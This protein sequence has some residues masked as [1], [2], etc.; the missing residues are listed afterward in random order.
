MIKTNWVT[1]LKGENERQIIYQISLSI[2]FLLSFGVIMQATAGTYNDAFQHAFFGMIG[3]SIMLSAQHINYRHLLKFK[4]VYYTAAIMLFL[5]LRTPLSVSING[6]TRWIK[7]AGISIQIIEP[8][9]LLLIIFISVVLYKNCYLQLRRRSIILLLEIW[10]L[11]GLQAV[12]ALVISS[13]LSSAIIVLGICFFL[14]LLFTDRTILHI[15][16]LT[17]GL[18]GIKIFMKWFSN[19]LP[20][21]EELSSYPYQL[22]RIAAHLDP[23]KYNTGSG[24]QIILSMQAVFSGGLTG[25]GLG[26]GIIKKLLPEAN[27]DLV[28]A[29]LTEEL[30]ILGDIMVI[31]LYAFLIISVVRIALSCQ[32][33]FG[34]ILVS[35]VGI[36]IAIQVILN[37][38]VA[39][40]F[41]PNT[42]VS[43]P[44]ISNGGTS[45][46][47][48][49]SEIAIV[50]SVYRY[51]VLGKQQNK[52]EIKNSIMRQA[53]T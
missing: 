46:V 30:G 21:P 48:L 41:I 43:L 25:R 38:A 45:V 19:H 8:I 13:N 20:Q 50:L 1:Y 22:S 9:K 53:E 26:N 35:G 14:T 44:W 40:N 47:L 18:A 42:G 6:A 37:I 31:L 32:D 17:G 33:M 5:L 11:I 10:A 34:M 49:C 4:W 2:I 15:S 3:V 12:L 52:P 29:V 27:S 23:Q 51:G 16:I 39:S 28:F 7:I 24:Y 36:H